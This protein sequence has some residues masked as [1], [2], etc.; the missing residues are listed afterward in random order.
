[1]CVTTAVNCVVF[2]VVFVVVFSVVFVV[3]VV[4]LHLP[5]NSQNPVGLDERHQKLDQ[6]QRERESQLAEAAAKLTC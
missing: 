2:S 5:L 1:M 3:L 4:N 6:L